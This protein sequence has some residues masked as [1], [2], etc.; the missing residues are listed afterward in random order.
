[1]KKA[2]SGSSGVTKGSR[3][4]L[5]STPQVEVRRQSPLKLEIILRSA[6]TS[7]SGVLC[8]L[9]KAV[10]NSVQQAAC[11]SKQVRLDMYA[12]TLS[13]S[14]YIHQ[15]CQLGKPKKEENYSLMPASDTPPPLPGAFIKARVSTHKYQ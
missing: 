7:F 4:G 12:I 6:N 10:H 5:G 15:A 9:R 2:K 8:C 13:P 14:K 11:F 3:L 1:M